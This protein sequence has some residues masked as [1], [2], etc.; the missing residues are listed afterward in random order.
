MSQPLPL[1]SAGLT[2][3]QLEFVRHWEALLPPVI[4]RKEVGW[5][6]GGIITTGVLAKEDSQG[7]GPEGRVAIGSCVAY[8]AR[9]LLVWLIKSRGM[10]QLRSVGELLPARQR[11]L[12]PAFRAGSPRDVSRQVPNAHT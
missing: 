9:N 5:F 11:H 2:P 3:E 8:H 12:S 10:E 7:R 1:A 6:L 4:A